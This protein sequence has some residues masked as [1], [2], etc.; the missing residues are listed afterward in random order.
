MV[1]RSFGRCLRNRLLP[2]C[3][4]RYPSGSFGCALT[5]AQYRGLPSWGCDLELMGPGWGQVDSFRRRACCS[6]AN[7]FYT[8]EQISAAQESISNQFSSLAFKICSNDLK[9]TRGSVF[10][11]HWLLSGWK[12]RA[13]LQM[14]KLT[15]IYICK[16]TLPNAGRPLESSKRYV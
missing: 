1:G 11:G 16:R 5:W 2:A 10:S 13:T 4:M 15:Y 3:A 12:W 6:I 7:N 9:F 14:L 8:A